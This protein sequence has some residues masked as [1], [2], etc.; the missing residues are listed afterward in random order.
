MTFLAMFAR[1]RR[2]ISA[3]LISSNFRIASAIRGGSAAGSD[4]CPAYHCAKTI[5]HREHFVV[6]G[7]SK[8]HFGQMV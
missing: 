4:V 7:S 2:A 3:D 8:W 6:E 1:R 5:P